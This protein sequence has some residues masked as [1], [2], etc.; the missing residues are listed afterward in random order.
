[1]LFDDLEKMVK[2]AMAAET[3]T[4]NMTQA[5]D[6][7]IDMTDLQT[8]LAASLETADIGNSKLGVAK[9]LVA[10]DILSNG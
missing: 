5:E 4:E 10:I 8:K 9:M 1:M 6:Q 7:P 3:D 2:A